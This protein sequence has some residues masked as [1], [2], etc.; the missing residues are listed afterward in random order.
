MPYKPSPPSAHPTFV[1]WERS[2]TQHI[3]VC[4]HKYTTRCFEKPEFNWKR[5][6]RRLAHILFC[7]RT[8]RRFELKQET[9]RRGKNVQMPNSLQ[10]LYY[11]MVSI[12]T[13][14]NK[15]QV[16]FTYI[17]KETTNQKITSLIVITANRHLFY[18]F[19]SKTNC[20][21]YAPRK[22]TLKFYVLH[23]VA[24]SKPNIFCEMDGNLL[25]CR[26]AGIW[27]DTWESIMHRPANKATH[28]SL[29][30]SQNETINISSVFSCFCQ[31]WI[32]IFCIGSEVERIWSLQWVQVYNK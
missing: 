7:A 31:G 25:P 29:S 24:K 19:T 21:F 13:L 23:C 5:G 28:S 11:Y 15:N 20:D 27:K 1:F 30:L 9:A 18:P 3:Y 10:D 14:C 8:H 22:L 4:C 26:E 16:G 12:C 2:T 32:S 6:K 17:E